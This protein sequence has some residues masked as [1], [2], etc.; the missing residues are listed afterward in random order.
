MKIPTK[1][2]YG[3]ILLVDL[4]RHDGEGPVR[5]GDI[6]KRQDISVKYLEQLIIQL[7]RA[8]LI[9]STR[10]VKGGHELAKDPK[11]ITIGEVFRIFEA[12]SDPDI[13]FCNQ[14]G[15]FLSDTCQSRLIWQNAIDA[16]YD[17]LESTSIADVLERCCE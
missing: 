13:C 14:E 6:S 10:G 5:V 4:A 9:K 2:R 1:S 11:Q 3:A 17:K 8:N 12:H 15:C 16:F 7:R